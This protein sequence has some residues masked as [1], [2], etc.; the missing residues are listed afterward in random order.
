MSTRTGFGL[1]GLLVLSSFAAPRAQT[2]WSPRPSHPNPTPRASHAMTYDSA[3]G[4]VVLFGGQ[5]AANQLGETWEW[6]GTTWSLM[7]T[8]GPTPRSYHCMAY[9]S[10]RQRVLMFGGGFTN[11][12]GPFYLNDTWEWDGTSW[13]QVATSG[14]SP[15]WYS[16]M[17][18]DAARQRTVLFGGRT[19]GGNAGDTW[20]WDGTSWRMVQAS[21]PAPR[22][23][24]SMAYDPTR[25]TLMFGSGDLLS[26]DGNAWT[27]I[28]YGPVLFLQA[29]CWDADRDRLV[30]MGGGSGS[31]T[32]SQTIEW[33]GTSWLQQA[34][35]P[36][37]Y[38]SHAM[39]YHQGTGEAV[40]FGGR[41]RR[42]V[43]V[44]DINVYRATNTGSIATIGPGC[45][46][47]MATP[48]LSAAGAPR[49]GTPSFTLQVSGAPPLAAGF[50]LVAANTGSNQTFGTCTVF[51][52]LSGPVVLYGLVNTGGVANYP[53]PL[54]F[55]P[56]LSGLAF[57]PQGGAI[58]PGGA[59]FGIA[60]LTNA[61]A[62]TVGD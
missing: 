49:T 50:L 30:V 54:P 53:F 59:L 11:Y 6:D 36:N 2:T 7:S 37:P 15:R 14:P 43:V 12:W 3:R 9:D 20:E 31:S 48:T 52:D 10:G 42:G 28:G 38:G 46:G 5:D 17:S 47:S 35:A 44:G 16:A 56:S 21:G 26:W 61:L 60:S 33:N 1:I 41:D 39:A 19:A 27:Q 18:Y 34:D 62:I 45:A 58:D 24:H 55:S 57:Y 51:P 22:S 32:S 8:T 29:M 25:Q 23:Q 4:R 40:H 13:T